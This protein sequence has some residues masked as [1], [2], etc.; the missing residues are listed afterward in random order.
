MESTLD[1]RAWQDGGI[2][3]F[4][5]TCF[6]D[7]W[8]DE[9]I[10]PSISS[11]TTIDPYNFGHR[12]AMGKHLIQSGSK[13]VWGDAHEKHWYWGYLAQLDWQWRTGRLQSDGTLNSHE[14][15]SSSSL[16][17]TKISTKSWFGYMNLNFSVAVYQGAANAGL[18]PAVKL[19]TLSKNVQQDAGFQTCVNIWY[20][21]WS[22]PHAKYLD[23]MKLAI[24]E[25]DDARRRTTE[26]EALIELYR[27]LWETH[28]SIIQAGLKH[29]KEEEAL[30]PEI[31]RQFGLG[32][33]HIV[34]LFAAMSYTL[35][36]LEA[37][38]IHGAGF[39]PCR[40]LMD[41]SS[42]EYLKTNRPDEHQATQQVLDLYHASPKQLESMC[43]FFR[44][45]TRWEWERQQMP[46]TLKT[47]N[48][49]STWTK[50]S[51]LLRILTKTA[52]PHPSKSSLTERSLVVMAVAG[53]IVANYLQR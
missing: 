12:M 45:L 46:I 40:V 51:L 6:V 26:Q 30:M 25:T 49:G 47:L 15:K 18:V 2:T 42:I 19:S 33:C 21:F 23:T 29:A 9:S 41:E 7:Y 22:G 48:K 36:S 10:V 50:I 24:K 31:E 53:P 32:W 3:S 8:N 11:T 52:L 38:M 37:L 4:E 43:G 14:S 35:L 27:Q 44:R 13:A 34:E 5:Q 28:S 16:P 17:S 20:E 39:L 1:L